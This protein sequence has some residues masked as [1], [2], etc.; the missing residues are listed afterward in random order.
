MDRHRQVVAKE[1]NLQSTQQAKLFSFRLDRTTA[2]WAFRRGESFRT[3][4][5]LEL[6]GTLLSAML[7]LPEL[8]RGGICSGAISEA[9]TTDNKGNTY[10][11]TRLMPTKFPLMAFLAET[12]VQMGEGAQ[13]GIGMA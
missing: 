9:G 12:A 6:F 7:F 13:F 4:A 5:S 3:I 8:P 10:A 2:P 11:L 1:G